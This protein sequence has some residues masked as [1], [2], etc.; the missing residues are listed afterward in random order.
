MKLTWTKSE[1]QSNRGCYSSEQIEELWNGGRGKTVT[2]VEIMESSINIR[3]KRWFLYHK[4]ELTLNQKKELALVAAKVVLPIFEEKYP[5]NSRVKD[6]IE[7]VEKFNK[8]EISKKDLLV[9][10][11]DAAAA[12]AAAYAAAAAARKA[13]L[14]QCADIVRAAYSSPF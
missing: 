1:L 12:A 14:K 11:C 2:L 4:G 10:R 7:A 8:G 6:C 5:N 9:F 3:D 13:T